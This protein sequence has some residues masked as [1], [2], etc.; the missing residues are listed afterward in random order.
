MV[1]VASAW[2]FSAQCRCVE[3]SSCVES[4]CS[5][6]EK[7][8]E[9][10]ETGRASTEARKSNVRR[11]LGAVREVLEQVCRWPEALSGV[12]PVRRR[13]LRPPVGSEVR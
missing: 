9:L 12:H 13:P 11:S 4:S 1:L 6:E 3:V 2:S 5:E 7:A 8:P 10:G